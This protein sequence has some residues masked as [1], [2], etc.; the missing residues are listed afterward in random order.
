M[1]AQL[2]DFL[3]GLKERLGPDQTWQRRWLDERF[4]DGLTE[5]RFEHL[6]LG[7]AESADPLER[8]SA[9]DLR[10]QWEYYK[11]VGRLL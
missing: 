4:G 3:A 6:L 9:N 7:C 1:S 10:L 2:D 5:T 8:A 11:A